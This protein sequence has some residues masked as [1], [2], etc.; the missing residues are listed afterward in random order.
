MYDWGR[1]GEAVDIVPKVAIN[2]VQQF[3]WLDCRRKTNVGYNSVS[4]NTFVVRKIPPS[5]LTDIGTWTFAEVRLAHTWL[6]SYNSCG[7][8]SRELETYYRI[9]SSYVL[10]N[11]VSVK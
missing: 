2:L 10:Y 3:I 9:M 6:H 7:C 4:S 11:A 8:S 1:G 5:C